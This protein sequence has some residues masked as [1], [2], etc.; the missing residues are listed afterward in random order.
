[1]CS[2]TECQSSAVNLRYGWMVLCMPIAVKWNMNMDMSVAL[3]H[4]E[5]R[6]IT[7]FF[8]L[9]LCRCSQNIKRIHLNASLSA[10][11]TPELRNV[12]QILFGLFFYYVCAYPF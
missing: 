4:T 2:H 5:W 7:R 3:L 11:Q 9:K 8:V 1:M 10:P 12:N 6:E